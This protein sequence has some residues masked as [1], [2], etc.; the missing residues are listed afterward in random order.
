MKFHL[1]VFARYL[2]TLRLQP[3]KYSV[4]AT[5][6]GVA[7]PHYHFTLLTE[8]LRSRSAGG[9]SLMG[10][11]FWFWAWET[12]KNNPA[13]I[14]PLLTFVGIAAGAWIAFLRHLAQTKLIASVALPRASPRRSSNSVTKNPKFVS[15]VF[16]RWSASHGRASWTT[17]PS[18]R[19]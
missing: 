5:P 12:H 14:A 10:G 19:H 1:S 17:G 7:P 15:V 11:D 8:A 9:G 16:T 18:W 13:I 3:S 6:T 4:E 2:R